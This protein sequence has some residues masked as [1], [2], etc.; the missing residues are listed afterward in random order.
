MIKIT[1]TTGVKKIKIEFIEDKVSIYIKKC[2]F[3]KN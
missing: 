2:I 1:A 3:A